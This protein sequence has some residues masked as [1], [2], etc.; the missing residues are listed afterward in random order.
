MTSSAPRGPGGGGEDRDPPAPPGDGMAPTSA[1][2]LLGLA[3]AGVVVGRLVRPVVEWAG[4][5][6]PVVSWSQPLALAVVAGVL[7]VTARATRSVVR[8]AR[9]P[10]DPQQAVNRL[11]LARASAV[12]GG[13]VGGGY[14]GYAVAWLGS[15]SLLADQRIWRSLL[16]AVC[17][18]AVV[19]SALLLERACRVPPE[20]L[21]P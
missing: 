13:F 1:T 17:A 9:A 14:A 3:L 10:L 11:L 12:V 15:P 18:A 6:A 4:A 16:T 8:V 21:A 19:V 20:D 7:A 2:F 5:V